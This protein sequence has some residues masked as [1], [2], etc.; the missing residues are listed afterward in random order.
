ME[1]FGD[2]QPVLAIRGRGKCENGGCSLRFPRRDASWDA[3]LDAVA[4][5]SRVEWRID[6]Y[7][8]DDNEIERQTLLLV[9]VGRTTTGR[10]LVSM[11][12]L[13]EPD[14]TMQ[15]RLTPDTAQ[16]LSR[17]MATE[18]HRAR[19]LLVLETLRHGLEANNVRER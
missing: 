11:H 4:G 3:L 16:M 14:R 9:V 17:A 18:D 5:R 15:V 6:G 8:R 12:P 10:I 19:R 1:T 7:L 13:S 2:E